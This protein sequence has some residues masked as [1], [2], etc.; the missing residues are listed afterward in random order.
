MMSLSHMPT[1][2]LVLPFFSIEKHPSPSKIPATHAIS[3]VSIRPAYRRC[4]LCLNRPDGPFRP[5]GGSCS[6]IPGATPSTRAP[7]H[8][9]PRRDPPTGSEDQLRR[10]HVERRVGPLPATG[11]TA[12]PDSVGCSA[13][14]RLQ[15][16]GHNLGSDEAAGHVPHRRRPV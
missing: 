16:G 2:S 5:G 6:P 3:T 9:E 14:P 7:E 4:G 13:G 15:S 8:N 11:T 10:V 1:V 12:G